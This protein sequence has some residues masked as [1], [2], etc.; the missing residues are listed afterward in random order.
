MVQFFMVSGREQ[1]NDSSANEV[2]QFCD[3]WI[4]EIKSIVL[5]VKHKLI[6]LSIFLQMEAFLPGI[7]LAWSLWGELA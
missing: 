5:C 6:Y 1:Q 4:F 2:S 7:P 3:S